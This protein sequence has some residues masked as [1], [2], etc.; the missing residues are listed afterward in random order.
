MNDRGTFETSTVSLSAE[1]TPFTKISVQNFFAKWCLVNDS[2]VPK[3]VSREMWAQ[4]RVKGILEKNSQGKQTLYLPTDLHLWELTDVIRTVDHD[5]FV[6]HPE[7]RDQRAD[8]ILELGVIFVKAGMYLNQYSSVIKEGQDLAMKV[9]KD[10]C[11]YG[12]SLQRGIRVNEGEVRLTNLTEADKNSLDEWFLGSEAHQKRVDRLGDHPTQT[13]IESRRKEL[14]SVCFKALSKE[15]Y[16]DEYVVPYNDKPWEIKTGPFASFRNKVNDQV[17]RAV[18]TPSRELINTIFRRGVEK[19]ITE[20]KEAGPKLAINRFLRKLGVDIQFEQSKLY[21]TLQIPRL[22]AELVE[23]RK[24]GNLKVIAQK[25]RQIAYRIQKAICTFPYRTE[26]YNPSEMVKDQFINC[27]G[28]SI[29]GG[30]LLDEVGIKYLHVDSQR[31]SITI[32]LTSDNKVYWQ[33]FTPDCGYLDNFEITN[34]KIKATKPDVKPVTT[35]DILAFLNQSEKSGMQ[36]EIISFNVFATVYVFKP[37]VGLQSHILES[38]AI[39][40]TGVD[41]RL[42][43]EASRQLIAINPTYSGGYNSL[44]CG[45][46][47]LGKNNEALEAFRM[48]IKLNPNEPLFYSNAINML[49]RL[50][51]NEE[52]LKT[53]KK[54]QTLSAKDKSLIKRIKSRIAKLKNNVV[55][56]FIIKKAGKRI[57]G[58]IIPETGFQ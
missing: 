46:S 23:V 26:A 5:T 49:Y 44:G 2:I 18:E 7:F 4:R 43:I 14:L 27:V 34:K 37:E 20:M 41:S 58:S 57:G 42:E 47:G 50:G 32:L 53:Y 55:S 38:I 16:R 15:G 33:D 29:V 28:S 6:R 10:F 39:Y 48:A 17:V 45:L 24:S 52:A 25:E 8:Q 36:F 19:L 3:Y 54:L 9:S 35:Q 51:R 30:G 11:N 1:N 22:R 12:L 56:E 13:Q 21:D 40:S 31:H